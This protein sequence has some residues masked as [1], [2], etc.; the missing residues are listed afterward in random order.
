M[1]LRG[2]LTHRAVRVPGNPL[3]T[4]ALLGAFRLPLGADF[5]NLKNARLTVNSDT[6]Y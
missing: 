1:R 4:A 3:R 5:G 6:V 2:S